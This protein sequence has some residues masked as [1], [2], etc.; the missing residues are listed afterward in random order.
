MASDVLGIAL[1]AAK[2]AINPT[3][4]L[5]EKIVKSASK[6]V[7]SPKPDGS[8]DIVAL[9]LETERQELEMRIAEAQA[10]VAQEVAI[11]RRIQTADE[12]EMEEYYDY[13]GDGHIGG[14]YDGTNISIGAG[15]SGRRVSK[16]IFK[17]KGNVALDIVSNEIPQVPVDHEGCSSST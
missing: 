12:V 6:N 16:R 5:L 13:S 2:I 7:E 15:G 4:Y 9:R 8:D 10:R 1:E 14:K 17:F 3:S 11:A